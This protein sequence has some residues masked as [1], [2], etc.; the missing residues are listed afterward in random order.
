MSGKIILVNG[1][2]SSGKSTLCR[3]LQAKLDEPFWHFSIDHIREA[4]ILPM[5][6]I[7]SG[8]FSW[9]SMRSAF[10]EG[11]YR[12]LPELAAAGNNLLVEH[13]V[14][15][16]AW[17]RRLVHLLEPFDVFFI[18]VHCPLPELERRAIG[19]GDGKLGEARSDY[20]TVHTF[21]I[22]DLDID[23]TAAVEWNVDL[24][25]STWTARTHPGAFDK[26]GDSFAALVDRA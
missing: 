3:G 14:E 20:E 8:D 18:G 25:I 22:Y 7:R 4:N 15:T 2:S 12:C 1:A 10:F 9:S 21:G 11:F 16:E 24:V 26:M 5:Q 6:R 13:I 23:S 19:R 17:M